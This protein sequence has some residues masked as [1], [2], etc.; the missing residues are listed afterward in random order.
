VLLYTYVCVS[1]VYVS[2]AQ[3][4][5]SVG[6]SGTGVTGEFQATMGIEK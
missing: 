3:G 4:G 6:S 1:P 5:Q 2:S